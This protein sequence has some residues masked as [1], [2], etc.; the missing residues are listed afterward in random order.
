LVGGGLPTIS[1]GKKKLKKIPTQKTRK[2][3]T[4]P[5]LSEPTPREGEGGKKSLFSVVLP[6]K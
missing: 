1:P 2:K 6:E 4:P 3:K 5:K